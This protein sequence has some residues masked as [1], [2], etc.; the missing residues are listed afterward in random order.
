MESSKK[1]ALALV[2]FGMVC[3]CLFAFLSTKAPKASISLPEVGV[4]EVFQGEVYLFKSQPGIKEKMQGRQWVRSTESIETSEDAEA[5]IEFPSNYRLKINPQSIIYFEQSDEVSHLLIKRGNV[6][7]ESYGR[8]GS[9]LIA[10]DGFELNAT[11]Y[12]QYQE[13]VTNPSA[14][15][16]VTAANIAKTSGQGQRGTCLTQKIIQDVLKNARGQFYKCYSQLLQKTPGIG[17]QSSLAFSILATGRVSQPE[18]SSSTLSD[19][20][21]KKCLVNVIER[22]EF[23]SFAG[24]SVNTVFPIRFE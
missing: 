4:I 1:W 12:A 22:V 10:K 23:P 13:R 15:R 9:V 8:E 17:G 16:E 5:I 7:V 24:A 2:S 20:Q 6:V 19:T 3:L 18:V 21:F 14:V 11:E